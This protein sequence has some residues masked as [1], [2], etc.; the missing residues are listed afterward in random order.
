MTFAF[1]ELERTAERLTTPCGA[2][3]LVW[4]RWGSGPAVVLLH[5][6]YGSWTHWIRNIPGLAAS[7]TVLA[8]DL[9]GLGDSDPAP[10]PYDGHS[11]ARIVAEG[12]DLLVPGRYHLTGFSFGG[13]LGTLIAGADGT[14]VRSLTLVGAG[15]NVPGQAPVELVSWRRLP[16]TDAQLAAHREN[17]GRLMFA[18]PALRDEQA[19]RLQVAN[20]S[21]A[22]TSSRPISR[23]SLLADTLPSVTAPVSAVFGERDATSRPTTAARIERLRALRPG[24]TVHVVPGAGHWVQ[25]E[26]AEQ[27]DDLLH[28]ILAAH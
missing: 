5:G 17:L 12:I 9:P 10:E 16:D 28:G 2:G 20:A 13:L 23:T 3:S 22:R 4:R 26:A 25:Y 6:G 15:G 18:D 19:V 21:R 27:F 11:L 8:A 24:I 14:R 1:A 7:Y